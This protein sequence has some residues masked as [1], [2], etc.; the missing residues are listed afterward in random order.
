[1]KMMLCLAML[2]TFLIS[3][4]ACAAE[5]RLPTISVNGEGVIEVAPERAT[6]SLGIINRD[7]NASVVQN[8]NARIASEIINAVNKLGIDRKNIRTG[9]YS[10]HPYY[11]QNENKQSVLD[12]YEANNTVTVIVDDLNLIGK[13]IDTALKNGANNV[14]SLQFGIRNKENLQAEA[15]RLAV[16]DARKKAEIV[17]AELGKK[18]VGVRSISINSGYVSAP[19]FNKMAMAEM[20]MDAVYETPIEAGT[21][22][23]SAGVNVEFEMSK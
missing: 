12:G 11:R 1:M 15:L 23:C 13:V 8:E 21:L 20:S 18:V 17:A 14:D 16:R 6:I 22:N 2:F 5:E 10:F 7:K 9:N 4:T 3:S 19:R